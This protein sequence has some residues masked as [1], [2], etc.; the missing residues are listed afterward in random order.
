[1][2]KHDILRVPESYVPELEYGT[3]SAVDVA[4]A[5]DS[6]EGAVLKPIPSTSR[7]VQSNVPFFSSS[8]LVSTQATA[9]TR[10]RLRT[11]YS[12][13]SDYRAIKGIF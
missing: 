5:G 12:C 2:S 8:L 13:R 3:A 1:M 6:M 10:C 7:L 9:Y 4:G 11:S